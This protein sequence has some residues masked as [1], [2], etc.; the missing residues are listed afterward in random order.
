VKPKVTVV[1]P[2][3]NRESLPIS[4]A[5]VSDQSFRGF[6]VIIV[7]DSKDQS[8]ESTIYQVIKTGGLTGVSKARNLGIAHSE[9]DFTALIDDDDFWHR[10][11]LAKQISN[12]TELPID[13]GLT[14]AIVNGR[15]RPKIRL[16]IGESPFE[17]LYGTPHLLRSPSYLPTSAYMFRTEIFEKI[18]FDETMS[19][20]ENLKF[21]WESFKIDCRIHQ[22]PKSLVTINYSMKNSLSRIDLAQ[23]IE[24]SRYLKTFNENWSHNFIAESA[25]NFIRY[26]D[27]KSANIL[28]SMINPEKKLL[29]KSFLK[30]LAL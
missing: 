8:I 12:F 19:D 16:K 5:S 14:G 4:L 24:W 28:I 18:N 15:N 29:L 30:L 21:I 10:D 27:R 3:I 6:E 7:D 11:Y 1:I 9:S 20:R 23:E 26:G 17:L 13:F 25:R 2:T 22:D